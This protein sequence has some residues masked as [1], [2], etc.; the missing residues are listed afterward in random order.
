VDERGDANLLEHCRILRRRERGG[1]ERIEPLLLPDEL[2]QQCVIAALQ[3]RL[4]TG[5]VSVAAER[6]YF[7]FEEATA[8]AGKRIETLIDFSGVPKGSTGV[9]VRYDE[10]GSGFDVGIQWDLTDR[11]K[12]LVDWFSKDEYEEF[13]IEM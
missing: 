5:E 11:S 10:A 6:Q 13:L 2:Q 8:K 12:P 9:V 4:E 3:Y 7:S 1:M